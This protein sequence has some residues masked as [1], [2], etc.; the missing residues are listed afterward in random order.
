MIVKIVESDNEL[1]QAYKVRMEVFVDEQKV[2]EEIEIDE[3]EEA[4]THFIGYESA[5][6]IAASRLR[7]VDKY[8]KLERICIKKDYRGKSYGKELIKEME[9]AII[10]KGYEQAKLN[11]QTHAEGF[12]QKLG[13]VTVSGEF[14]DAGIPHVTM[15]KQL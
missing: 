5:T 6:P 4:A 8:G 12:Y 3:H 7:F 1:Q 10:D 13:Y 15:I 9:S 11:A 2:P 14:L